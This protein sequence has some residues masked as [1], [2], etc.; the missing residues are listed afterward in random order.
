MVVDDVASAPLLSG[1]V[2]GQS[3]L[4]AMLAL[5]LVM[6]GRKLG[7]VIVAFGQAH[8]FMPQEVA[9]A[10]QAARQIAVAIAKA[11][12]F[13]ETRRQAD[14]VT[15][16]SEA[17]RALNAMPDVAQAFP[18]IAQGLRA[19]SGCERVSL[20]STDQWPLFTLVAAD[21]PMPGSS[22]GQQL[23]LT[24]SSA[25]DTVRDG[26]P[27]FSPAL[28]D[29]SEFALDRA[30]SAAGYRSAATFPLRVGDKIVGAL[31]LQWKRLSGFRDVNLSAV[32]QIADAIA[33]ASEKNRLFVE[34]RR[35]ADEL[36]TLVEVSASLRVARNATEM[37][38]IFLRQACAVTGGSTSAIFMAEP[39]SGDL[40]LRDC[41]PPT[42]QLAGMRY[43]L[44][45]GITGRVALTGEMHITPDVHADPQT[46]LKHAGAIEFLADTRSVMSVP[47]RTHEGVIGVMNVGS[48]RAQPFTP[49]EIHLLTAIAEVA[50]NAL[51]RAN[52]LETLEE[53]VSQRTRELA[54]ANERLKELDR[55]KD[56][57]ISNVS[58]E[59]RTPLTNIKLHLGMLEKRGAEV[60]PRYLP[61][62]QR[63]TERLRRLIEDLLDLSRL[64][65]QIA[66]PRRAWHGID[67][68]MAE[69]LV[70][71][72]T[73][74]E[75]RGLVVEH[76]RLPTSPILFVDRGQIMQVFN[77]LVG[78]AVA[79]TP[80]GG[81]LRIYSRAAQHGGRAGLEVDFHND[82]GVIPPAD[83]PHLFER[84]FRGSTGIDSGEAGTGLGL[85]I[86][87]EILEQHGGAIGVVS[88][89]EAGTTFT[90]WLPQGET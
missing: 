8:A 52:L 30:W 18:G 38:P 85:S 25:A 54:R 64:Q 75:A 3:H 20:A 70:L 61:T 50:G 39:A 34:T 21:P 59:L 15:A 19:I 1:A 62:L 65:A 28:A 78:N 57:F 22:P 43:R 83:L 77:N 32:E 71:H 63:E 48:R 23:N 24:D 87:K 17:L 7:A 37:L 42:P 2:A 35:R 56:Q 29:Q 27:H 58:H 36:A 47:L 41:Y 4:R 11:Q 46:Q 66:A 90:V 84:F 86:C 51:Q 16:A 12:L 49:T 45:E 73:R 10:E 82:G 6:G 40:V 69:V 33:L 53:R 31:S 88:T 14:E 26:H 9:R 5:P 44:G 68:L 67:G 76:V 55:L 60:L 89:A 80:P 79:Y 72:S 81:K 74:A 13:D